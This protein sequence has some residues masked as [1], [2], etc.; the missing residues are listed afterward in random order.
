[1]LY[2]RK[3]P[4]PACANLRTIQPGKIGF[5]AFGTPVNYDTGCGGR[6]DKSDEYHAHPMESQL[7]SRLVVS[8]TALSRGYRATGTA[9]FVSGLSLS[10]N[11]K[12]MNTGCPKCLPQNTLTS[13]SR[14]LSTFKSS[15]SS[16]IRR[17][18]DQS[19][20]PPHALPQVCLFLLLH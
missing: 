8:C 16:L 15:L 13:I 6:E 2:R 20:F 3:Y 5:V 1:M 7:R 11:H 9:G 19:I 18:H 4:N 17:L 12:S 10:R 14:S